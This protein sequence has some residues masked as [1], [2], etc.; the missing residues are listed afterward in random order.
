[1]ADI[2]SVVRRAAD[3][4][5][6]RLALVYGER[7]WTYLEWNRRVNRLAFALYELG[8]CPGDRVAFYL[9][10]SES[11]VTTYFACQKLGAIAVPVNFRLSRGELEGI[12]R[13]SGARLLVYG[14]WAT[15]D[16]LRL[17]LR[18]VH[19]LV[20]AADDLEQVP[21]GH[22]H[23][24]SLIENCPRDEEPQHRNRGE[25]ASALIYTSGT[26][27]R[28][29]GV[30]HTHANDFAIATNCVMEYSLRRGDLALHVAPLYHVGGLQAY[31]I[32]HVLVGAAN[33]VLGRY[34]VEKTMEI[35]SQERI[36]SLFAVPVQVQEIL[37]HPRRTS[38]D[39]S[40]LRMLTTGGASS[41]PA[42]LRRAIEELCPGTYNGYGL[43]EAS[44]SLVLA[45][46]DA[47]VCPESC[48]KPTLL[49]EVRLVRGHPDEEVPCGETGELIV[50]G[51][52]VTPGYWNNTLATQKKRRFG[53]LYTGDLF[54]RDELGFYH[55][56]GRFDDMI[57]SGGENIQPQEVEKVLLECPG[58]KDGVVIGLPHPRWGQAV[59]AVVVADAGLDPSEVARF[60]RESAR[61]SAYK[62][63]KQVVAVDAL[64]R[65]PTGKVTRFELVA[66]FRN[67]YSEVDHGSS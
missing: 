66:R 14:S 55:F 54:V 49:S 45:P 18:S 24:E 64:P 40:S 50:R 39:L 30:I 47:L 33:V 60:C 57:V 61:L 10:N 25:S 58:V 1:M 17:S 19:D 2:A 53:W 52:H 32:P 20:S 48:G 5:P 12:L 11:S 65:N 35:I 51:P 41:S 16:V 46:E 4:Y 36:T 21:S 6:D 3:R 31:F 27:G 63:P 8:I 67:L 44:L 23:L 38:Y 34:E 59:T 42:L 28:P 15:P 37:D 13:D 56:R 43:T 7:R 9:T 26:T 29:K 22:H 62:C